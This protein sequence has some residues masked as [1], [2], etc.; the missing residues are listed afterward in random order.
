MKLL[1]S[2]WLS[3]L[4]CTGFILSALVI[5]FAV[6]HPLFFIPLIFFC[7]T[8]IVYSHIET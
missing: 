7:I 1:K 2:L 4:I 5:G 8:T 6:E 3:T